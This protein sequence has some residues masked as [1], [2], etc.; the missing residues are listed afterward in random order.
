MINKFISSITRFQIH[1]LLL[2]AIGIFVAFPSIAQQRPASPGLNRIMQSYSCTYEQQERLFVFLNS[3]FYYP[4]ENL[5]FK[6]LLFNADMKITANGSRFFYLQLIDQNGISIAQYTY[7]LQDGEC[8]GQIRLPDT[9]L[10]GLYSLNAFTRWMQCYSPGNAFRRP[11]LIISPLN[12]DGINMATNDSIPVQFYP[13]GGNFISG[14]E[15]EMLVR[16]NPFQTQNIR[17]LDIVDDIEDTLLSCRIDT[18]GTGTF[19]LTPEP[20]REYFAVAADSGRPE[21]VF[22]LPDQQ[23]SGYCMNIEADKD[24]LN[25]SIA[26]GI[27]TEPAKAIYLAVMNGDPVK[28]AAIEVNM[29]DHR[30]KVSVPVEN[31]SAGLNQLV[32]FGNND[33]L[34]SRVWYRENEQQPSAV[35]TILQDTLR[36]RESVTASCRF[37]DASAPEKVLAVSVHE[38]NPVTDSMFYSEISHFRYFDLYSSFSRYDLLPLFEESASAEYINDCLMAVTKT[39]AMD[40][41]SRDRNSSAMIRETQGIMLTGKVILPETRSPVPGANVLLSSPDSVAHVD[42]CMTNDRGEFSFALNDKLYNKQV[43]I[44]VQHYPQKS[45]P[46]NIITDDPFSRLTTGL[47]VIPVVHP[48]M[49]PIMNGH[50]NIAMAYRVFYRDKPRPSLTELHKNPSYKLNFYG[51]PDFKLIPAE[52]EPLPDLFEIRKNLVPLLKLKVEN[53]HCFIT[54][55][56]DYLYLFPAY[57]AFVLINNIPY[58]S[59]KNILELNSDLIRS[60]EIKKGRLF[61]DQYLMYGIVSINTTRPMVVEPYFSYLTTTIKVTPEIAETLSMQEMSEGTMPDVRHS[62]YWD[63]NPGSIAET[64]GIRFRSSDIKGK[65]QFKVFYITADGALHYTNKVFSVL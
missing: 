40:F 9:L 16:I 48:V 28:S 35:R 5:S 11:L 1:C 65:Y 43:Y 42:Y 24:Y 13:A 39:L 29:A 18:S 41:V 57:Q 50:K 15:N 2:T 22:K 17:H 31:L 4:G 14:T 53:D 52:Y 32:L 21:Q 47:K 49:E 37:P 61:Y 38:Y 45:K 34:C 23:Y 6:A 56:D 60:I 51:E 10:S 3:S 59:L 46:V 54:V 19:S 7:E 12:G 58:P 26:S 62:L 44:T 30:G 64:T 36:T 27:E 20:G 55:F 33:V 8:A 63:I 25:I